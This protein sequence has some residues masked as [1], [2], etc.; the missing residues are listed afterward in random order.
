MNALKNKGALINPAHIITDFRVE[1][2]KDA[3]SHP[4]FRYI[5]NKMATAYITL[6]GRLGVQIYQMA[7]Q[8][9]LSIPDDLSI[10]SFDDP[11][12][13]V[14]EFSFFTHIKQFEF[15]MG[16]RAAGKLLEIIQGSAGRSGKYDKMLIEPELVVRQ[17]TG[18]LRL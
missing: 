18:S 4:L 6:N 14:E 8:A 16:C 1:S 7:R 10:I 9:G 5:R 2:L 12:S 15:E 11:T 3:Q 17:T 13:I